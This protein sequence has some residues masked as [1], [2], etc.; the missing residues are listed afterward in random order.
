LSEYFDIIPCYEYTNP[1]TPFIEFGIDNGDV[2]FLH[3]ASIESIYS[4]IPKDKKITIYCFEFHE[5][6]Y[7]HIKDKFKELYSDTLADLFFVST[8]LEMG[9]YD[10]C[11]ACRYPLSQDDIKSDKYTPGISCPHCYNTHT[12]DKLKSLTERQRQV[13]LAKE[14]GQEHLGAIQE[15][16]LKKIKELMKVCH[17]IELKSPTNVQ[18][19]NIVEKLMPN[20]LNNT[21]FKEEILKFIQGDLRK[22]KMLYETRIYRRI[23]SRPHLDIQTTARRKDA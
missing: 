5:I 7:P 13:I 10:Q 6:I 9:D 3:Q 1:Y 11:Y 17:V 21:E 18:I 22:I 20:F 19:L 12:P 8:D 16:E 14:R 15:R 4:Y 23:Y 2:L